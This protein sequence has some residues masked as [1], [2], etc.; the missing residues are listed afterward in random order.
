MNLASLQLLHELLAEFRYLGSNDRP[1][2]TLA[3]VVR[4][5]VLV[6]CFSRVKDGEGSYFGDDRIG[7]KVF[8]FQVGNHLTGKGLLFGGVVKN[9]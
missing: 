6:V 1:A 7:P 5:I 8:S 3:R 2:V 4:K 9:R